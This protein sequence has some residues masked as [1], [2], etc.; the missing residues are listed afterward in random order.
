[1]VE[2]K[3]RARTEDRSVMGS[4]WVGPRLYI[5]VSFGNYLWANCRYIEEWRAKNGDENKYKHWAVNVRRPLWE[6]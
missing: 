2:G 5:Q 4:L 3:E 6:T 1:L